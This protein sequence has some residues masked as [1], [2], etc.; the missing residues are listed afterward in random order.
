MYRITTY[1]PLGVN[2]NRISNSSARNGKV[3]VS[4][5]VEDELANFSTNRQMLLLSAAA[6]SIGTISSLVADV[7]IWLIAGVANVA[8]YHRSSGAAVVPQGRH[9]GL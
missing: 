4:A 9:L 2:A 3:A 5:G 1:S 7:L 6:P 8:F